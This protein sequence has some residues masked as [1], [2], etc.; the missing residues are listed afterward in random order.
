[1][2]EMGNMEDTS[3]TDG[4]VPFPDLDGHCKRVC[5]VLSH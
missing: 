3:K 5:H 4:K 1:M 2:T